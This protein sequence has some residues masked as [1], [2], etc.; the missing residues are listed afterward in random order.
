MTLSN[1][2][3]L[4]KILLSLL[5]IL[6]SLN[7]Y[8]QLPVSTIPQNRKVVLEEFTGVKC[9]NCPSA[10]KIANQLKAS[11]P[12]GTIVLVNVHQGPYA[13]PYVGEPD[14]RTS[15]GGSIVYNIYGMG[16]SSYPSG[17]I[18]RHIFAGQTNAIVS[19]NSWNNYALQ[20]LEMPSY[21]N[22]AA[23]AE[24]DTLSRKLTV[25][26]E[27]YYTGT[28]NPSNRLTVV[29]IEDSIAGMQSGASQYYPE[30]V[31]PDG[32][33]LH[34]HML[35]KILTEDPTGDLI[36]DS[37]PAGT[38]LTKTLY[39]TIP[40]LM[41]NAPINLKK[42]KVA[43]YITAQKLDVMNGTYA[44]WRNPKATSSPI[45]NIFNNNL[46]IYPNPT[47]NNLTVEFAPFSAENSTIKITDL[48]GKI[49]YRQKAKNK[50]QI[51]DVSKWSAGIYI[52]EYQNGNQKITKQVT[53]FP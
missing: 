43:A 26:V 49:V 10:H 41:G 13:A 20:I 7:L 46:S 44:V 53:V 4:V 18:N 38:R 39:F 30:M 47:R 3:K 11:H 19:R 6:N 48:T 45:P 12:D 40:E 27:I 33:Y 37:L 34:N 16:V 42:L 9:V 15:D 14:Y 32:K 2:L 36:S 28:G 5:I 1:T 31:L 17:S 52:M 35:R 29:L 50:K 22:I 8:A 51:I 24:L 23:E 21:V 25:E